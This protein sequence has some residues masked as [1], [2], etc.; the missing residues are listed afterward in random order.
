M[1]K[2]L[3]LQQIKVSI[4]QG[5]VNFARTSREVAL[6][7]RMRSNNRV[8]YNNE[9]E[10]TEL[11]HPNFYS[12]YGEDAWIYHNLQLPQDG[13][14]IDVGAGDGITTSNTFFLERRHWKGLC[15]DADP[16][17][18]WRLIKNRRFVER[19][20]IGLTEGKADF[21]QC[22]G[23]PNLS[24]LLKNEHNSKGNVIDV[25]VAK[26][27]TVMKKRKVKKV[28]LLSIDT[29]GTEIDVWQSFGNYILKPT[30]VI[31]EYFGG[32]VNEQIQQYFSDYELV[33]KTPANLIFV[34]NRT[35]IN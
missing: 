27:E 18:H 23:I 30:I 13:F 2:E 28:D 32:K 31:I 34:H 33:H 24:G 7:T 35:R 8:G 3:K 6:N 19:C 17:N 21:Y 22:P 14:F 11:T 15:I 1:T 5:L 12:E 20:A 16:Q 9:S 4:A 25:Q 29:E 26:L 10:F